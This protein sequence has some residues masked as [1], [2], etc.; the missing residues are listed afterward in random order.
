MRKAITI[1]GMSCQ[2]CVRHVTEA[3]TELKGVKN[4]EVNLNPG[5]AIIETDGE[6]LDSDIRKV[7]DE[8]GYEVTGIQEA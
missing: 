6:V 8:V 3:L 4:V 5:R 1:E 7:V 2:H